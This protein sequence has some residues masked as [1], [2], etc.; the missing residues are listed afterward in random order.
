MIGLALIGGAASK[1]H[2][3]RATATLDGAMKGY[4]QGSQDVAAQKKEQFDKEYKLAVEKETQQNK[5]YLDTLSQRDKSIKDILAEA[6]VVAAK[7]GMVD[8]QDAIRRRDLDSS[9]K[10]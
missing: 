2:W 7:Y 6:E 9:F 3:M 8:A 1:S 10:V 4:L 5:E